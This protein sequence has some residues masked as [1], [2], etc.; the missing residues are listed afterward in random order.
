VQLSWIVLRDFRSYHEIEFH[1]DPG[2]NVLVGNNG[3]G[4]TSVL[5]AVG[6]LSALRSFRRTPDAALVRDGADVGIVRGGFS[7]P[8]GEVKVE[9]EIPTQGRRRILVNGK[10]PVRHALVAVEVPLVA[11]LPDDLDLVKRGPAIRREYLDD[12][13]ARLGPAAGADLAEYDKAVRQRNALLRSEGRYTDAMTLDVWDERIG[14]LGSRVLA[15]RLTLLDRLMPEVQQSYRTVGDDA[16]VA[17][18][19]RSS[20]AG[21]DMTGASRDPSDHVDRLLAALSSR[22]ER[23]MEQRTTSTGPHRDDV[24]F[25]IEGRDVRVQ[26]SQGEQRST[27]L[28][29]R[30]AAYAVLERFHDEAPIL[31]LD[32]VFSEL[33]PQRSAGVMDLL[34]RG[35]VFVTSAREDEVPAAGRRWQ[36]ADGRLT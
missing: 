31:L 6:Y 24:A 30:L 2:I 20:W 14:A 29:L 17:W 7:R 36:V 22:R 12:L 35:Q 28:S 34:P 8:V 3:A 32:D 11:F 26:A 25:L 9:V 5:E 21:T 19:Y 4:K 1:P 27:A 10:R 23:D 18:S 33:D 15:H 13:V 16:E